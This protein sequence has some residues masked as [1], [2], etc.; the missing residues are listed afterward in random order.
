MSPI[1]IGLLAAFV[2]QSAA[3]LQDTAS[4]FTDAA[5]FAAAGIAMFWTFAEFMTLYLSGRHRSIHP[6]LHVAVHSVIW[7]TALGSA[8]NNTFWVQ[9]RSF[10]TKIHYQEDTP[11]SALLALSRVQMALIAFD[12]CL[13][14]IHL[15]MCFRSWMD[16][17]HIDIINKKYVQV[18]EELPEQVSVSMDQTPLQRTGSDPVPPY[19]RV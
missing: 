16:M 10:D 18:P 7:L 12:A 14:L 15:G 19:S 11:Y 4:G 1:I 2:K 8:I 3:H 5:G 17:R 13:L 6:G 9:S